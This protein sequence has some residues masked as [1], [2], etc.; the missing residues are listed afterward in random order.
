VLLFEAG[1]YPR[2]K[3]CG[4]Y[5]SN[6]SKPFLQALGFPFEQYNI[7]EIRHFRLT[8]Y[9]GYKAQTTLAKGGFGIS[10]YALDNELYKIALQNSVAVFTQTRVQTVE[11]QGDTLLLK[12]IDNQTFEADLVVGAYGRVSNF[13]Q[14]HNHNSL[15]HLERAGVRS[16]AQP[17]IGVK[18][19]IE[20]DL[21]ADEIEIHTFR[22]GYCGISQIETGKFCL[23]Y[24]TQNNYLKDYKGDLQAFEQ[25]ILAE[26]PF[27]K[28]HLVQPKVMEG[29]TTSQF[30]FGIKPQNQPHIL[31]LGDAAGFIPPITGNGMSLAFR[32]SAELYKLILAYKEH[33][34][35]ET[36]QKAHQNYIQN[37][38]NNRI[39]QG[40]FL[41]N[42]LF[43]ENRL[44]QTLMMKSFQYV[45]FALQMM[46]RKAVGKDIIL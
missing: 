29:V 31:P 38:L 18:Y 22:G 15:S 28:R 11:K 30:Y 27:L 12:T 41:Q 44:F 42:L 45:P 39:T 46:T 9:L 20:A 37:Y 2:H 6:E 35:Y 33:Q 40:V 32:A 10:R 14:N 5:I 1:E 8:H 36:L 21:P 23:C 13:Q 17:F 16:K 7:P 3:V 34:R 26:N 25:A 43:R 19:H 4:E 24:L